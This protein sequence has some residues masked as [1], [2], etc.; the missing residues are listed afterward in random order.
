MKVRLLDLGT[1]S[2]L[3]SQTLFHG[4]A[5]AMAEDSPNTIPL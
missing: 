3:Q 1:V 5:Y 2:Y 4:I